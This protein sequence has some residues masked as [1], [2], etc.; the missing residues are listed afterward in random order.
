MLYCHMCYILLYTLFGKSINNNHYCYRQVS[1]SISHDS[2][3]IRLFLL[4][5]ASEIDITFYIT[6]N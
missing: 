4:G 6:L 1:K 2:E 3:K 5:N